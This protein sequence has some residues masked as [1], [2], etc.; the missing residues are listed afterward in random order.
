LR[1]ENVA[2]LGE[3]IGTEYEFTHVHVFL[4]GVT[5]NRVG[6]DD[7]KVALGHF[8]VSAAY[9]QR[10]APLEK[11][12]DLNLAVKMGVESYFLIVD[13]TRLSVI[14]VKKVHFILRKRFLS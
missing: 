3:R 14:F 6:E 9:R 12:D 5:V 10:R 7:K 8:V 11:R 13:Y 4:G 2:K 1:I